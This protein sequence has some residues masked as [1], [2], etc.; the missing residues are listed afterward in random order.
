MWNVCSFIIFE[1]QGSS[2]GLQKE[3]I[4]YLAFCRRNTVTIRTLVVIFLFTPNED[5]K[6]IRAYFKRPNGSPYSCDSFDPSPHF[7]SELS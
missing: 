1:F 6:K 4:K 2:R 5:P 3:I 7:V